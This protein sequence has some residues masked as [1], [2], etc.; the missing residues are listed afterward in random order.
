MIRFGLPT[1]DGGKPSPFL[2]TYFRR[3]EAL[4]PFLITYFR[5]VEVLNPFLINNSDILVVNN[6]FLITYPRRVEALNPFLIRSSRRVEA[7]KKD[8]RG[9]L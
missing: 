4:N 2:I 5:R 8:P 7:P 6:P 1:P 9:L 3:V